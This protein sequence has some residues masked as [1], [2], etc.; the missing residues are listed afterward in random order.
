MLCAL[1]VVKLFSTNKL[2]FG[3]LVIVYCI[4]YVQGVSHIYY[5]K[6]TCQVTILGPLFKALMTVLINE[7]IYVHIQW[8][9]NSCVKNNNID[10]IPLK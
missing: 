2:I 1:V 4:I 5:L 7:L 8:I 9:G 6:N 10:N 3:K